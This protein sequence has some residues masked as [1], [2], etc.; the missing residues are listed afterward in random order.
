MIRQ[1]CVCQRIFKNEQW[2][3]P[4][5][6]EL[7]GVEITHGYCEVCHEEFKRTLDELAAARRQAALASAA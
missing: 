6:S 1:C 3:S 7:E 5:T 2:V 4:R